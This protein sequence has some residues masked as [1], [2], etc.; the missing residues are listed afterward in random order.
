MLKGTLLYEYAIYISEGKT[1]PLVGAFTKE[2]INKNGLINFSTVIRVEI[3][4]IE[5]EKIDKAEDP[6]SSED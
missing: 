4:K 2:Q 5:E 3:E 1:I 6:V